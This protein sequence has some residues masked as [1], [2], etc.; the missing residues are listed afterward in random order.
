MVKIRD[1]FLTA[2][3][4]MSNFM[5]KNKIQ[6]RWMSVT[7]TCSSSAEMELSQSMSNVFC[8]VYKLQRGSILTLSVEE[9]GMDVLW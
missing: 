7:K 1:P 2:K 3:F 6:F 8:F 9:T 4:M 5:Q